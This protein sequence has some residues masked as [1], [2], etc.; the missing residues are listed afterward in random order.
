MTV[1]LLP[2]PS[3]Y[4]T[5]VAPRATSRSIWS[6]VLGDLNVHSALRSFGFGIPPGQIPPDA[7]VVGCSQSREVILFGHG[8][9]ASDL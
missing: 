5:F 2:L 4:P 8:L 6:S 1:Q 9:V 3:R 7:S